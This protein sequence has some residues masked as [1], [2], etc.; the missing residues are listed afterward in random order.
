MSSRIDSDLTSVQ[1]NIHPTPVDE[2][3]DKFEDEVAC[4]VNALSCT[5]NANLSEVCALT[6]N[7]R[8]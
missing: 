2:L 1:T 5:S 3:F 8:S 6:N 7:F 4:R